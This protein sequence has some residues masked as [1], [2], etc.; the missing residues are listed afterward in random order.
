MN[1]LMIQINNSLKR[2]K[3][4]TLDVLIIQ[5]PEQYLIKNNSLS[6]EPIQS[7]DSEIDK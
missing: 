1:Q 6:T 3:R 4:E 2:M 7:E 5:Y